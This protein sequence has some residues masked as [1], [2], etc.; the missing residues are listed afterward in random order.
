MYEVAAVAQKIQEQQNPP[1]QLT[2]AIPRRLSRSLSRSD[3]LWQNQKAL[4]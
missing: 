2:K 4:E 1:G 3:H